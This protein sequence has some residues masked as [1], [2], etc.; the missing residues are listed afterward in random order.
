MHDARP[1]LFIFEV[2]SAVLRSGFRDTQIGPCTENHVYRNGSRYLPNWTLYQNVS[3]VPKTTIT[4]R[5]CTEIRLL[6]TVKIGK[7]IS[8][9]RAQQ[10]SKVTHKDI[11]K[12]WSSVRSNTASRKRNSFTA[13]TFTSEDLATHFATIATDVTYDETAINDIITSVSSKIHSQAQQHLPSCKVSKTSPKPD[14]TP[15]WLFKHIAIELTPVI[16]HI[17][18]LTLVLGKPPTLWKRAVIT[19]VPKVPH[20]KELSDFRPISV[21]PLLSR[22]AERII[23]HKFL[24]PNLPTNSL[25]DQFA[26]RPTCSTTSCIV[27]LE[28]LVAQYLETVSYVRCLLIDLSKAFDTI[29]HAILFKKLHD[30][31]FSPNITWWIYNFLCGHTQAVLLGSIISDWKSITA[32][33][34][35]GSGTVL[36]PFYS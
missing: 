27:A 4:E 7:L 25:V 33:I 13:C 5:N 9:T 34:V 16:T 22:I 2:L 11:K 31:N 1:S 30:L 8:D 35:Q 32:S 10:L 19:P 15:Y 12:L 3:F 20:P 18:N 26:Y 24:L 29:N 36:D 14:D 6:C 21:T 23:V 28:H 17:L